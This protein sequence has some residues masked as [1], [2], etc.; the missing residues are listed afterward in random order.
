MM[1]VTT[2]GIEG[3]VAVGADG[4]GLE[5]GG[6]RELGAAGAAENGLVLPLGWGPEFDG[7]M[8]ESLVAIFASVVGGAAF[9]FDGNDIGGAVVVEAAGLGIEIE[10]ADFE[11]EWR[12]VVDRNKDNREKVGRRRADGTRDVVLP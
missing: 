8:G 12:H 11:G 4:G 6:D 1:V 5:V 3:G 7:V 9:H 10:T 2:G